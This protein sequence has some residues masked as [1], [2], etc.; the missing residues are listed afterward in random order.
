MDLS[1][2]SYGDIPV[3]LEDAVFAQHFILF[4][5]N[6]KDQGNKELEALQKQWFPESVIQYILSKHNY[7]IVAD[8]L[9]CLPPQSFKAHL[10]L[11]LE[12][13]P[14]WKDKSVDQLSSIIA[15]IAPQ[16][17]F[18]LFREFFQNQEEKSFQALKGI[19]SA[20]PFL[21]AQQVEALVEAAVGCFFKAKNPLDYTPF[22]AKAW[23]LHLPKK[24]GSLLALILLGKTPQEL[25]SC[26]EMFF[27]A[28]FKSSPLYQFVTTEY[29]DDWWEAGANLSMFF[30]ENAP[31]LEIKELL[32]LDVQPVP[33]SLEL[34]AATPMVELPVKELVEELQE[35]ANASL[36]EELRLEI[37]LF[38]IIVT[39]QGYLH[40]KLPLKQLE[41]QKVLRLLTFDFSK[42]PFYEDLVTCIRPFPR[43]DI[44][45]GILGLIEEEN[46][47]Y[48]DINLSNLMG[49]L[50]FPEFILPLIQWTDQD[51]GDFQNESAR[52]ALIK[53]GAACLPVI[54]TRWPQL[55]DFQQSYA[56]EI[57]ATIGGDAAQDLFLELSPAAIKQD[58]E[59]WSM[60]AIFLSDQRFL[61]LLEEKD[62]HQGE[63]I[64][65]LFYCLCLLWDYQPQ[66]ME[67][68]R[69]EIHADFQEKFEQFDLIMHEGEQLQDRNIE[70]LTLPLKCKHCGKADSYDLRH[71]IVYP[72][73]ID[74][75]P[76]TIGDAIACKHCALEGELRFRE[77]AKTAILLE[78]TRVTTNLIQG[79][80]V[81]TPIEFQD[82]SIQPD[83]ACPCNSG[84]L[85]KNCCLGFNW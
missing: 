23:R 20:L 52:D 72:E 63:F 28:L 54:Q 69:K 53:I 76:P 29:E 49:D 21:P 11:L 2:I 7:L 45:D 58:P 46:G 65:E 6:L 30:K 40:K 24:K 27:Q 48:T 3:K 60:N 34:L 5:R 57:I 77:Q 43:Q 80:D 75:V 15:Q 42:H 18:E 85:F 73:Y 41:L 64:E 31:L 38:S 74:Q 9:D 25:A 17:S 22:I 81:Q 1:Q 36:T 35:A 14:H 26:L 55:D 39:A 67:K 32:A 44:I 78:C 47:G 82:Y 56:M 8:L 12:R 79:A 62:K 19:Y 59:S 68:L 16:S 37:A 33:E 50:A 84:K 61:G 70:Y 71:I 4:F 66:Q 51:S 13:W 83:D 10:V